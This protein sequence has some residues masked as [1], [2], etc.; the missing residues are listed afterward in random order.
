[1]MPFIDNI[2][3]LVKVNKNNQGSLSKIKDKKNHPFEIVSLM[4]LRGRTLSNSF[5][6]IDECQNLTPN[7]VKTIITRAGEGTKILFCG[8]LEQVD[9]KYLRKNLNGLSYL[10]QN[11]KNHPIYGHINLEEVERSELARLGTMLP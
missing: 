9:D 6:I 10:M 11:L 3:E 7:L 4:Y 1:M 5:I 8:D 2:K